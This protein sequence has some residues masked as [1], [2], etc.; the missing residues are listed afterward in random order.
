MNKKI[1][2]GTVAAVVLISG[3][4]AASG[5]ETASTEEPTASATESQTP[6]P[7]VTTEPVTAPTTPAPAPT[8]EAPAPAPT[9]PPPAPAA[10]AA[11]STTISQDNALRAAENY[12]DTMPFSYQGL[13]DQLSSEYGSQFTVAQATH[14]VNV[15]GL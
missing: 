8:V 7:A 9:T 13:I 10:P 14:A 12:L 5:N 1:V 2:T 3:I 15:L 6:E 11:P 4:A